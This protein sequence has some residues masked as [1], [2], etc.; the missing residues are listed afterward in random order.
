M[1]TWLWDLDHHPIDFKYIDLLFIFAPTLWPFLDNPQT[2]PCHQQNLIPFSLLFKRTWSNPI[3]SIIYYCRG[4]KWALSVLR[5]VLFQ[6]SFSFG[7]RIPGAGS[8]D[9]SQTVF[10]LY[11]LHTQ[12]A[13]TLSGYLRVCS[14]WLVEQLS[15]WAHEQCAL[16]LWTTSC[17]ALARMKK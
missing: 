2:F 5:L 7:R 8:R 4:D 17:V 9:S 13:L 11:Y 14:C 10:V 6:E 12:R 15:D 1:G 16:S 3:I